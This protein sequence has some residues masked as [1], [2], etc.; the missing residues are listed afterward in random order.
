M[1]ALRFANSNAIAF[2]IP[3]VAPVT[4]ADFP[5]NCF[6]LKIVSLQVLKSITKLVQFYTNQKPRPNSQ[7]ANLQLLIA[8]LLNGQTGLY[9][10]KATPKS[11]QDAAKLRAKF[12]CCFDEFAT[13]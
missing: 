1:F 5:V 8:R 10:E 4:I 12:R 6:S 11:F 7:P 2:P 13:E 3:R 9:D